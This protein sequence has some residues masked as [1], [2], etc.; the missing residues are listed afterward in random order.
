M[1]KTRLEVW[2]DQHNHTMELMRTMFGFI[3][4]V[5]GCFVFLKVFG[6]I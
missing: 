4:A 1:N 5:T 2:L 6:V 3:A